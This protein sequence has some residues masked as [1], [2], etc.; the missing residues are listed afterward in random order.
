MFRFTI[1][2]V[3]W[4]TVVIALAVG[5]WVD[6]QRAH[7]RNKKQLRIIATELDQNQGHISLEPDQEGVY[8]VLSDP[9]EG[10]W[11]P[12]TRTRP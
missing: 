12:T 4:L 10:K 5:W 2:D 11:Q 9:A 6:R 7:S 8:H 3:L 1:R